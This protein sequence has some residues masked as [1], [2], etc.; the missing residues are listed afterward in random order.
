MINAILACTGD[1]GIGY[2]N[3]L[4]WPRNKLDLNFFREQ[5]TGGTVVMGRNTW[6]SLGKKL[7]NR[8]NIV[9]SSRQLGGPDS[10]FISPKSPQEV[11]DYL[12]Q[13]QAIWII[14]GAKIYE[15]F[16]PV[17]HRVLVTNIR[18]NYTCDTFLPA[19]YFDGF[20][21]QSYEVDQLDVTEWQR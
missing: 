17:T 14:G 11:I 8:T 13:D 16:K 15:F 18:E 4:P 10:T 3:D 9:I 21:S 5:T 2:K 20:T 12:P 19:D 7:P 1:L 6:D